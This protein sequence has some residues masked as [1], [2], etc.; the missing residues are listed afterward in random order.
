MGEQKKPEP[1]TWNAPP[2]I[3]ANHKTLL[4]EA[5]ISGICVLVIASLCVFGPLSIIFYDKPKDVVGLLVLVF[6]GACGMVYGCYQMCPRKT[7]TLIP[8]RGFIEE[9]SGFINPDKRIYH[10]LHFF[11]QVRLTR[12]FSSTVDARKKKYS[13]FYD[14]LLSGP[15]NALGLGVFGRE[16]QA[17]DA[18]IRFCK[19]LR[20]RLTDGMSIP[21]TPLKIPFEAIQKLQPSPDADKRWWL[22]PPI[23]SLVGANLVPV[24][25][26]VF[27]DWDVFPI[28]LFYW[29]ENLAIAL[30]SIAGIVWAERAKIS[31]KVE[32]I[33]GTVLMFTIF[34][35]LLALLILFVFAR[36]LLSLGPEDLMS[37]L[38]EMYGAGLLIG[39]IALFASHAV[40]FFENYV[41]SLEYK[42]A[43]AGALMGKAILSVVL[44]HVVVGLGAFVLDRM[45]S[46]SALLVLLVLA[47][48]AMDVFSEL[49]AHRQHALKDYYEA[50]G[51]A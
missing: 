29:L 11:D 5:R 33:L 51:I 17:L 50:A 13:Y 35:L 15:D 18:A 25:G 19:L 48:V 3:L 21:G 9:L 12:R 34:Q 14:V 40:A 26:V 36:D 27:A 22:R 46:P 31:E 8:Q 28:V 20:L 43:S 7:L 39:I 41:M 30:F 23:V 2:T 16:N 6:I 4:Y 47:K 32:S 1:R 44:M 24:A 38:S 10:P 37:R 42:Q 45:D 49:R